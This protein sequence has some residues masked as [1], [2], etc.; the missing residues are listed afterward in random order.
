MRDIS[1]IDRQIDSYLAVV[2]FAYNNR[3]PHVLICET[4]DLLNSICKELLLSMGKEPGTSLNSNIEHL[5][6]HE[7]N[8]I[9]LN[10]IKQYYEL[11]YVL[12]TADSIDLVGFLCSV[13]C[14]FLELRRCFIKANS[15]LADKLT[16]LGIS[17]CKF[18]DTLI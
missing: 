18:I 8:P 3:Y 11:Q 6:L 7:F 15:E 10:L 17:I 2:C 13:S 12:V 5:A 9:I 1:Y 4:T 14:I 16:K